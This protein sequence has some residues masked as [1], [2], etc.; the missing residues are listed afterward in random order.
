M[1]RKRIAIAR[2]IL[3]IQL[4]HL[5]FVAAVVAAMGLLGMPTHHLLLWLASGIVPLLMYYLR[6]KTKAIW[7]FFVGLIAIFAMSLLLPLS[8]LPKLFMSAMVFVYAMFAIRKK[9][10]EKPEIVELV[11][12]AVFIVLIGAMTIKSHSYMSLCYGI[13]WAYLIGYFIY[14]FMTEHLKFVDINENSA[15]NMP[16]KE[17]FFH[18]IG[19]VGIFTGIVILLSSLTS[20]TNW[21]AKLLS[22]IG[23]WVMDFLR[24]ILAGVSGAIVEESAPSAPAV[25]TGT[26]T[27]MFGPVEYSDLWLKIQELL[28][29]LYRI[30]IFVIIV[31]ILYYGSRAIIRFVKENFTK[32]GKKKEAKTILSNQDIRE[33]CSGSDLKKEKKSFLSFLSNEQRIRTLYKK[34]MLQ[35]K[36]RIV[37]E[38]GAEGLA[39]LTAKECCEKIEAA[40]LKQVYEKVRYS[41]EKVTGEDVRRAKG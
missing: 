21:L 15:S 22:K 27:D 31:A 30:L 16:E 26:E 35:E 19:Q 17:L 40:E 6:I 39:Y 8:I 32:V 12:P 24:Y 34:R 33:S 1:S 14:H 25:D 36:A 11:S 3:N 2:I 7:A 29:W 41:G 38:A 5:I 28:E 18:G 10:T 13:A 4:N 20:S 37:G 9:M 23:D